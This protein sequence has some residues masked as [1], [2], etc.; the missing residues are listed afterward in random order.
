[1]PLRIQTV[2]RG[3]EASVQKA[4]QRIN[5]RGISVNINERSFTRPLGKITGSVSEFNKSL[6]ASNARVLAFG[7]SVGIIQGVQRAFA[8]LV[9]TTVEVEKSLMDMNVVLG[10]SSNQ[11]EDFADKL[12]KI[13][14]NT[15]QSF[16]QVTEAAT[17]FARQGLGLEETLKRTNDALILT[18]L[19]GIDATAAV[20]GLTAAIN[21]FNQA[22]LDS[23]KILS[24]M[25]AVDV[26]FAVS[27][28]DLV[29]GIARAGAVANDAGVSFDE[30]IAAVT[31]AQ[32][33]TAR[34]G[35]VI[36]NSFKTIFTRLQRQSTVNRLQE[37]GIAVKDV[38]AQSLGAMKIMENHHV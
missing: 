3:L 26:Q 29:D 18:R 19:T 22:G 15:A 23:T 37:L 16:G 6:E 24:K 13:S 32:Q 38:S 31:A 8:G 30:L 12:F 10:I 25:A 7:A 14:R 1:M 4:A 21:T 28:E 17:E 2:Q 20:K 11:L 33:A 9:K 5:R 35:K 34:G 27:M 36:G